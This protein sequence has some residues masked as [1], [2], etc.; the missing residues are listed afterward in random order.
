[1]NSSQGRVEQGEALAELA[2]RAQSCLLAFL[3]HGLML[4]RWL[5]TLHLVLSSCSEFLS[6]WAQDC[7]SHLGC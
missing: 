7:G 2:L 1:M 3:L 4:R 5:G 6:L